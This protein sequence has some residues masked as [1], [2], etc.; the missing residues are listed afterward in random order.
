MGET[1]LGWGHRTLSEIPPGS[2][3]VGVGSHWPQHSSTQTLRA[4]KE[5]ADSH[6][7]DEQASRSRLAGFGASIHP[8]RMGLASPSSPLGSGLRLPGL[9]LEQMPHPGQAK[10]QE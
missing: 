4:E 3:G 9:M 5:H 10:Q 6:V 8:N 2:Q 7:Q 1:G